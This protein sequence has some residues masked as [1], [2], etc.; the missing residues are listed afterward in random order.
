M[1]GFGRWALERG[2][3]V[4]EGPDPFG[5]VTP[6]VHSETSLHYELRAL[7]I[8]YRAGAGR[9]ESEGEALRWLYKKVLRYRRFHPRFPLDEMF[10]NGYGFI[11]ERGVGVNWPILHH[12]DHLHVGFTVRRW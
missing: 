2:F 1:V 8:N 6:G 5:P 3:V 7:D 10:F 4:G 12:E 9:W 11:K